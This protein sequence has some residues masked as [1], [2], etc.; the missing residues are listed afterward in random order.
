MSKVGDMTSEINVKG[1]AFLGILTAL[2]AMK[3]QPFRA[4]V[5]AALEGEVGDAARTGTLLAAGWYPVGWYRQILVEVTKRAGL[6]FIRQLGRTSTRESV[7]SVHRIFMRMLSPE[8]LIK[9]GARVFSS[10]YDAKLEVAS[11]STGV[12]RITWS[13]CHGFDKA[14]WL[15]QLGATEELVDMSGAKLPR[16]KTISGGEDG[17][18]EMVVEVAWR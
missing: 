8:T 9:Q 5:V 10:F 12:A 11:V 1:T 18:S 2:E 16:V 3:G 4:D 17:D 6:P 14:C 7:S 13:G 15:D